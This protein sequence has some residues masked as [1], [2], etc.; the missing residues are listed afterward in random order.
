VRDG[1][2]ILPAAELVHAVVHVSGACSDCLFLIPHGRRCGRRQ[3]EPA[4]WKERIDAGG[5][6]FDGRNFKEKSFCIRLMDWLR[7]D[8]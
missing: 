8:K 5:C 7:G 6:G 2:D 3:H 4:C 1:S